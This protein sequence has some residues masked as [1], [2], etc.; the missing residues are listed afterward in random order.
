M[1]LFMRKIIGLKIDVDT[2]LGMKKGVPKIISILDTYGIKGSFFVPMGRDNTGRTVKRV[3]TRK[4]FLRKAKRVGVIRTYG[5]RTLLYG[6]VLRGPQIAKKNAETLRKILSAGHELGIH[7]YDHV[8]WHDKIRKLDQERTKKELEKAI[9]TYKN[10]LG[11]QP[12]SFASPGWV[13]NVHALKILRSYNFVYS[14]DT[15]GHMPFYPIMDGESV[16]LLQ[17]PTTLPTLDEVIGIHGNDVSTLIGYYESILTDS[18]NIMT[19]HA[20]IEGKNWSEF[21]KIFIQ[22]TLKQKYEYL[23]LIEIAESL[24]KKDL[25]YMEVFYGQING[26]AGDVCIQKRLNNEKFFS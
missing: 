19:I 9:E 18:L 3:F 6:L 1:I 13:T 17:I 12:K 15:R 16:P 25:P 10:V 14:S 11:V 24:Q 21:L 5:I 4:G 26:R 8:F 23:T 22:K 20:E 2:F 7:G